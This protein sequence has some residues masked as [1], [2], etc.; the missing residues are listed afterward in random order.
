[1]EPD[2]DDRTAVD[3]L[4]DSRIYSDDVGICHS[5]TEVSP[6]TKLINL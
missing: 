1:M 5:E 6:I 3:D 2:V 4:I